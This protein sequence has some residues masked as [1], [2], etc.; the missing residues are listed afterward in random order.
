MK[1]MFEDRKCKCNTMSIKTHSFISARK[2]GIFFFFYKMFKQLFCINW[3]KS[4]EEKDHPGLKSRF[5]PITRH[6]QILFNYEISEQ[7]HTGSQ[8]P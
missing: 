4:P 3:I 2:R 5:F 1:K 6:L 8:I 7:S